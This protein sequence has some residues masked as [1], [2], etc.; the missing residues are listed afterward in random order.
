MQISE[1]E[2]FYHP[3]NFPDWQEK[4]RDQMQYK[5]FQRAIL[6]TVRCFTN[7]DSIKEYQAIGKL[8]IPVLI[9]W[10]KED[11]TIPLEDIQKLQGLIPNY[12]FF[13]ID[14][15]GHIPQYEKA[16]VVN[17]ILVDFFNGKH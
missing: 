6:S 3:E 16:D 2:D 5:G 13:P 15:A 8:D 4:Y 9:M 1:S 17:P 11:Q 7:V 12:Q 14:E 10:G